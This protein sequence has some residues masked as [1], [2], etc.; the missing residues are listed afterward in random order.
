MSTTTIPATLLALLLAAAS[1]G[2]VPHLPIAPADED[3]P[4]P[5]DAPSEADAYAVRDVPVPEGVVL[6]VGGLLTAPDDRV[7][8]CTRRGDLWAVDAASSDAP[9]WTLW[10]DGL[11]EPLGLLDDPASGGILVTQRAELSLLRDT[12]GDDRA[13]VYDTVCDDWRISG[14]YHE[15]AFGPAR[16]ADGNLWV[17]LNRPFDAEPFGSVP[18]RGWAVRIPADGGPMQPVCAGLRSPAGVATAPWG[19]IFYTDNQGEWCGASKLAVLRMG[20]FHGH[21]WGIESCKLPESRVE[22]P[23]ELPDGV[24]MPEAVG[25][26]PGFRLPA[27]WFPYDV[28]GRSPSGFAWDTTDGRF[29]PFAGQ[30]F[31]GDQYQASVI[32]VCLEQVD[33]TWQ[34]ACFP[35]RR[36]LASGVIRVAF[37]DASAELVVGCSDRGWPSLGDREWGLQRIAFSGHTPFEMQSVHALADGF[38]VRFTEPV[39]ID[40]LGPPEAW[41]LRSFTYELHSD[42]GSDELD[43]AHPAVTA[44]TPSDEGLSVELTVD[45]LREGYVHELLLPPGLRAA[46]GRA[47][48]H[49]RAYY[50][51]IARPQPGPG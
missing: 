1:G 45:C 24:L 25:V 48:L 41:T 40:T 14:S 39:D 49:D 16:D 2:A 9:R 33:G 38:R 46:D 31:V 44:V 27:V 32:R 6:E 15:Y 12:D 50:T 34:G 8:V 29:G 47:A 35:F 10:A 21:P 18:W 37:D 22:F 36:G 5:A 19:D 51:L 11:F 13:D 26:I 17:T 30:L 20:D 28:M 7:Y 23:G 3:T 4:T 42:Y 43:E